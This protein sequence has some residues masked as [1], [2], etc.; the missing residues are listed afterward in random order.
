MVEWE[1]N[2][3]IQS[4]NLSFQ[5]TAYYNRYPY[6]LSAFVV[7]IPSRE[8]VGCWVWRY[9]RKGKRFDSIRVRDSDS[10]RWAS[11]FISW[12]LGLGIELSA[13]RPCLVMFES[14]P[15]VCNPRWGTNTAVDCWR[16]IRMRRTND[17]IMSFVRSLRNLRFKPH[18]FI[19]I[20]YI[21]TTFLQFTSRASS[22]LLRQI[23]SRY[24]RKKKVH[25]M[26]IRAVRSW[27]THSFSEDSHWTLILQSS[28]KPPTESHNPPEYFL[29]RT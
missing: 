1:R 28:R 7:S 3:H 5:L 29:D 8:C 20:Y 6:P 16:K 14:R 9:R 12:R 21:S 19:Q 22:K 2:N 25:S 27:H 15:I 23:D 11:K 13:W 10:V 24:S 17:N 26:S 18:R 4:H